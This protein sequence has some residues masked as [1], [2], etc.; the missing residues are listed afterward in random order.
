[1]RAL[2]FL[3]LIAAPTAIAA[4]VPKELRTGTPIV[5]HGNWSG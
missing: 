4:L 3:L 1:V 5:G 2:A